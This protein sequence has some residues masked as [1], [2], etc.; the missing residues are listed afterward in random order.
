VA[1]L[2]DA[3]ATLLDGRDTREFD[4]AHVPGSINVTMVRAAVGTRAAWVVDPQ[5][6]VVVT[7]AT[8]EEAGRMAR[9]L[10]AVGFRSIRGRLAGGIAAWGDAGRPTESTRTIDIG[11]LADRLRSGDVV[12]LDVRE[13]DEWAEG[14]VEG[15]VHVPYHDL[16]DGPPDLPSN[17][18][19]LAVACSVGNRSSIAVSLLR[20][21]GLDDLIHVT[22]GGIA[23]LEREGIAL[24]R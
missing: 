13:G 20:R 7:A 5:T 10:E 11:G 12:L 16:R 8:D 22:D 4:A 6:D 2:L 1:E 3:G 24:V 14:H 9:L 15:S 17:G 21:A 23:D 18:K 19:P